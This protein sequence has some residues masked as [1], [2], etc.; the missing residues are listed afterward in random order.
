MNNQKYFWKKEYSFVLIVNAIYIALFY[1][2][3]K[4]YS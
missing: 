3:M 1:V 2:V 4:I